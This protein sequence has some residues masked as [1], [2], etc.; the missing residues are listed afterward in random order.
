[1]RFC[2]V[3]VYL[4]LIAYTEEEPGLANSRWIISSLRGAD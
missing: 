1:M 4:Q 2:F 3:N